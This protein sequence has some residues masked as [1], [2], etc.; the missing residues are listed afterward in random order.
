MPVQRRPI[1]LADRRSA[2]TFVTR[3]VTRLNAELMTTDLGPALVTT[4]EQTVLDLAKRDPEA[5]DPDA[6]QAIAALLPGLDHHVLARLGTVKR[7][8]WRAREAP[9]GYP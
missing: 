4:R 2:V 1:E 6:Q 3:D 7:R 9:C 5:E 8:P